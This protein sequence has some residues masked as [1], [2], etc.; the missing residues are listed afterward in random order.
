MCPKQLGPDKPQLIL[1]TP[2]CKLDFHLFFS[3]T[4]T[5]KLE[6]TDWSGKACQF[7]DQS[8]KFTKGRLQKK[9]EIWALAEPPLTPPPPPNLGPV[10]RSIFLLFYSNLHP[11]KHET[12]LLSTFSPSDI[13]GKQWT[14][15]LNS[16][17][18]LDEFL[19]D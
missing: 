1:L 16:L 13:L 4:A 19:G 3:R 15:L 17:K 18:N 10:I 14:K 6:F 7:K 2:S 11:S 12:A 5:D 9:C 8:W